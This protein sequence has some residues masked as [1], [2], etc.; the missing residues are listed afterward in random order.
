MLSR[1]YDLRTLGLARANGRLSPAGEALLAVLRSSGKVRREKSDQGMLTL[2]RRL[3][4]L[5]ELD[6]PPFQFSASQRM[7]SALFE[8]SSVVPVDAR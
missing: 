4:D 2:S 5:L 3:C 6:R 1:E 7:W 8:A